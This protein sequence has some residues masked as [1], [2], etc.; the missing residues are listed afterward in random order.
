MKKLSLTAT[1]YTD[2]T[3]QLDDIKARNEFRFLSPAS[4]AL[5]ISLCTPCEPHCT[6]TGWSG[7]QPPTMGSA[8]GWSPGEGDQ[9]SLHIKK[10]Q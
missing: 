3:F 6:C 1:I 8:V 10:G 2:M 9:S 4:N 7:A 5:P